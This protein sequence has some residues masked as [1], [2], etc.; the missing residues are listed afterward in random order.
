M[1]TRERKRLLVAAAL[2][3]A[4]EAGRREPVEEDPGGHPGLLGPFKESIAFGH[5]CHVLDLPSCRIHPPTWAHCPLSDGQTLALLPNEIPP[6]RPPRMR[7]ASKR[8]RT[9]ESGNPCPAHPSRSGDAILQPPIRCHAIL[10]LSRYLSS[11]TCWGGEGTID[12]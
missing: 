7:A 11:C 3:I 2:G 9:G 10:L 4:T 5:A 8:G 6:L 1:F 12:G